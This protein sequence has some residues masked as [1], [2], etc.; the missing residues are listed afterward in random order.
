[1]QWSVKAALVAAALVAAAS[2]G[3]FAN[4][5]AAGAQ[6]ATNSASRS[7]YG[8]LPANAPPPNPNNPWMFDP[9]PMGGLLAGKAAPPTSAFAP[10]DAPDIAALTA[11]EAATWEAKS[12]RS[13]TFLS[14]RAFV[15]A[16]EPVSTPARSPPARE[17][18]ADPML[19]QAGT[20]PPP[21]AGAE[22]LAFALRASIV[23]NNSRSLRFPLAFAKAVVGDPAIAEV[24][25]ISNKTLS[26]VGLKIGATNVTLYDA[27]EKLLG[28]VYV[29]VQLD[30]GAMASEL[31]RGAGEGGIR[32]REVNGNIVLSGNVSD[33]LA[34]DR[35]MRV[36]A[37]MA[38]D[39]KNV[40]NN[41]SVAAPQQVM[42]QVRF[43]EA[44][45]QAVRNLGVRWNA[46]W[47]SY[48]S[49]A[50]V[51]QNTVSNSLYSSALN[52][53]ATL[54]SKTYVGTNSLDNTPIPDAISGSVTGIASAASPFATILA[55][56]VNSRAG[57][58]DLVLSA[59]E[60]NQ[61]VRRLAEPN[62]VALSG[63]SADFLA[64]GEFPV[65]VSTSGT[66]SAATVS[67]D[68]KQFGVRLKFTPTV[69]ANGV[70][71]LK[72][73]SEVSDIDPS[74]VVQTAGVAVPGITMR[75]ASSTLE[76]RDGQAFAIA[77]MLQSKSQ[78]QLEALPWLGTI[79]YLG[80]LFSSKQFQNQETELV[81]L[82]SPH[83]VKPLP[84]NVKLKTPLDTRLPAN[85]I[86]MFL[87]QQL[88][89]PKAQPT[90][91]TPDGH[92]QN[93]NGGMA[94]GAPGIQEDPNRLHWPWEVPK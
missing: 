18:R 4:P 5:D 22:A 86:D 90:Y 35:A 72:L 63:E 76:L 77:G 92:A 19:A 31:R 12:R 89:V 55:N 73:N 61:V 85:D 9:R 56:L 91:V 68:Y 82:V 51:G 52:G 70:I 78:R 87:R 40:V 60:E 45:R 62:L 54:S 58:L 2:I 94:P 57:S 83:V 10:R 17:H 71:S 66:G 24:V 75:R 50:V 42:L 44:D 27:Q 38:P 33:G 3:L 39:G 43:V 11:N 26:I 34:A 1:M 74:I 64:G 67:I 79:P 59:L 84:P 6:Q 81:M 80:A 36:A 20:A 8:A 53:N 21:D 46:F 48:N 37:G 32:V 47:K 88:E 41:L 23:V 69:L 29:N 30:T 16:A 7:L 93:L 25:P 65:P 28:V 13:Q 49:G 15:A 14:G